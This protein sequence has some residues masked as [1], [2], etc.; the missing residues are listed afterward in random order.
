AAANEA[1]AVGETPTAETPAA[2]APVAEALAAE[3]PAE[4]AK[5]VLLWRPGRA[6]GRPRH[7]RGGNRQPH[8]RGDGEAAGRKRF[9]RR[10][11]GNEGGQDEAR[12]RDGRPDRSKDRNNHEMGTASATH[13]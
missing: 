11:G 10:P 9:E 12:A 7:G 13:A 5:P 3:A 2:D 6:E 4:E 1:A 8:G